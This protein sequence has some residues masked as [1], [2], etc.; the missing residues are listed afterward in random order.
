M[1]II[2]DTN[3]LA[4]GM[5][6]GGIPFRILRGIQRKKH[7]LLFQ[8]AS[9]K[10]TNKPSKNLQI[11]SPVSTPM[12]SWNTLLQRRS[13]VN[14]NHY[15]IPFK[16]PDDDKFIA[17]ALASG[18]KMIVSGDKHLLDVSGYHGIKVLTPRQF[19]EKYL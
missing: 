1:R 12:P 11:I 9:S 17:C 15:P 18:T 3:V 6:F 13:Y 7:I 2:I 14:R 5:F 10:N 16:N 4:S 19:A 8:A